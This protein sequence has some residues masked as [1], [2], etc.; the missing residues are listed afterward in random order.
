MAL[1]LGTHAVALIGM[2]REYAWDRR[3]RRPRPSA[4]EAEGEGLVS[5]LVPFRNEEERIGGLLESLSRQDYPDVEYI[6]ID[7]FSSDRSPELVRAFV[8][9]NRGAKLITLRE[10]PGPNRKQYAIARGIEAAG[11]NLLLFTDADCEVPPHWIRGMKDRM[12]DP[13]VAAIIAPVFKIPL[14][15]FLFRQ[16][17][18]FDHA[19]RYI[20]LMAGTGLGAAGGGFGNNLML[21]REALDLV[22]GYEKVPPSP[23]EDAAL[24]AF[25]RKAGDP[26]GLEIH[27]AS[28]EDV[29][30]MTRGERTWA[31][32]V[33]QTLRWNN[34]G[35]FGPDIPTRLNFGLLMVTY[36]IGSI[37]MLLSPFFPGLWPLPAGIFLAMIMNVIS[38]LGF[39]GPAMP[40]GKGLRK[41]AYIAELVT[42]P[43]FFSMLTILGFAG[44]KADWKGRQVK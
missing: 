35:L 4:A 17:Q 3:S 19:V 18:C 21:R 40:G 36:T 23:T 44:V 27:S 33:N 22:G 2:L 43:L 26:R 12:A 31:S 25:I 24:V 38:V 9:G 6:F 34:G 30:V 32:L 16:Y 39:F 28:G 29:W 20:Y 14:G 10:N 37:G 13:A 11:G 7:D 1:F 42:A 8:A 5:V 41:L 15:R